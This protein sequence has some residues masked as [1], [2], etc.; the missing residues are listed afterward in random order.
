MPPTKELFLSYWIVLKVLF[1]V[2]GKK[3]KKFPFKLFL[4]YRIFITNATN[5]TTMEMF[6]NKLKNE[7]SF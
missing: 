6:I 1:N 3:L 5:N 2:L 4:K 7:T